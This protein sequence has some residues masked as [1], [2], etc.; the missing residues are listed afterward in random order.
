MRMVVLGRLKCRVFGLML[1]R[2]FD[3]IVCKEFL[4]TIDLSDSVGYA[5]DSGGVPIACCSSL[6]VCW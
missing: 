2:L 4:F 1:M 5:K 3:V 6:D